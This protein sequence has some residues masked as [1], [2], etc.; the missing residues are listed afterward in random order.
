MNGF[1][2]MRDILTVLN[3]HVNDD[4]MNGDPI[5]HLVITGKY[6]SELVYTDTSYDLKYSDALD[7]VR[8]ILYITKKYKDAIL[9]W[10]P[11]I[12]E[13]MA[14]DTRKLELTTWQEFFIE[15]GMIPTAENGHW[16]ST[17]QSIQMFVSCNEMMMP[18]VPDDV[19]NHEALMTY[20]NDM[21]S[22]IQ[23]GLLTGNYEIAIYDQ[24]T[25]EHI[26][27][28]QI[29]SA[30]ELG[31]IE[32]ISKKSGRKVTYQLAD[33]QYIFV[34]KTIDEEKDDDAVLQTYP[35]PFEYK[36]YGY[37]TI[38]A[39]SI[40]AAVKKAHTVLNKMTEQELIEQSM[41]MPNSLQIDVESEQ[42]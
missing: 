39:P 24:T 19:P 42:D 34:G 15:N 33:S 4:L 21:A 28:V 3:V 32:G 10:H 7:I 17:I 23:Q 13:T 16:C 5:F 1:N 8:H 18:I 12:Y 29:T 11:Q 20:V 14:E 37:V 9:S 2:S 41:Y 30:S 22:T 40:Q 27:T 36:R 6:K 38:T 31:R 26:D 25:K 35:I